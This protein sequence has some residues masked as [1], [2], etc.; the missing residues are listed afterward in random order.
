MDS[1]RHSTRSLTFLFRWVRHDT[2]GV[3]VVAGWREL[4]MAMVGPQPPEAWSPVV[5]DEGRRLLHALVVDALDDL[6][7]AEATA[8]LAALTG[9]RNASHIVFH[10]P[11]HG[12]HWR[13][14]L[15]LSTPIDLADPAA[16]TAWQCACGQVKREL[17]RLCE[18]HHPDGLFLHAIPPT[19][20][21]STHQ[22]IDVANNLPINV[23]GMR[24]SRP[25][26]D[27]MT[28]GPLA[29]DS[30]ER[31]ITLGGVQYRL[32]A[33]E[34][35]RLAVVLWRLLHTAADWPSSA[36]QPPRPRPSVGLPS[37]LDAQ[38]NADESVQ[39]VLGRI[40]WRLTRAEAI[41][42]A[43]QLAG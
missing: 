30:S 21:A 37:G 24:A 23:D 36:P 41:D 28:A 38:L 3:A 26:N 32:Y 12:V 7:K 13:V 31:G 35:E 27:T 4:A 25:P 40:S 22:R 5:D 42:L 17:A 34:L 19:R 1:I 8:L 15:P 6:E 2:A 11:A 20:F 43:L 39:L 16:A 14:V 33:G 9:V 29:R 18:I 10:R